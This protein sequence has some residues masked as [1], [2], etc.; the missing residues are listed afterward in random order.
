M[1]TVTF[2]SFKGGVGRTMAL[3]NVATELAQKGRR[4]LVVDFDLEA[5]GLDTFRLPRTQASSGGIVDFVHSYRETGVAPDVA[6]YLS[7]AWRPP[8]GNGQLWIMPSGAHGAGYSTTLANIDWGTLYDQH[9]GYL[10]F[11]DLKEQWRATI[12][13]DYVLIDSRTGHTDTGGI[14]TRQLP[15]AV[16][17]LFFPN[18][19]NLRGLTKIVSDIKAEREEPRKKMVQLHYVMSNV[20][21]IDDEDSILENI[22]E[23]FKHRLDLTKDPMIIH[24][25]DSLS[26]LNQVVFTVDR[27][28]SRLSTEYRA[29]A[30]EITKHNPEDRIGALDYIRLVASDALPVGYGSWWS[31]SSDTKNHLDRIEKN[32]GSDGEVLFRLASCYGDDDADVLYTKAIEANYRAPAVYLARAL[33]RFRNDRKDDAE[34][35]ALRVLKSKRASHREKG[36]A[37]SLISSRELMTIMASPDGQ[38]V[39]SSVRYWIASKR[40]VHSKDELHVAKSI[41][42]GLVADRDLP[43]GERDEAEQELI[44]VSI[45]VGAPDEALSIIRGQ[46]PAVDMMDVQQAFN[47]GMAMWAATGQVDKGAFKRVV[48]L[49]GS[50]RNSDPGDANYMQCMAVAHWV[51][52]QQEEALRFARQAKQENLASRRPEFSCWRYMKV[53]AKTFGEDTDKIL[54]MIAGEQLLPEVVSQ[55][56]KN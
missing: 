7:E 47:Y 39:N 18:E 42:Q 21:D 1:Y 51:I 5:P 29:L 20:P 16:V 36:S 19:Q 53:S 32:H 8:D 6:D 46:Q 10:L 55:A 33:L 25:Y 3:V 11:E 44:L 22:K 13:P 2:Y 54:K 41:L 56:P 35:D 31:H 50:D 43:V 38:D 14:C 27:P 26:L 24:R 45:G 4:V 49:H 12:N 40:L 52:D 17:V 9:D 15:D 23:S 30:S 48:E 28:R 37:V 34:A